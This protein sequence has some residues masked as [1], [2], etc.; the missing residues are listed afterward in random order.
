MSAMLIP[1]SRPRLTGWKC[2]AAFLR[3]SVRQAR[4]LAARSLEPDV[5]LP[6]FSLT[7]LPGAPVC[8]YVDELQA[9][10]RRMSERNRVVTAG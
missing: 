1:N 5:R 10:E 9:W 8:A 7:G 3:V 2:L 6:V 4:R